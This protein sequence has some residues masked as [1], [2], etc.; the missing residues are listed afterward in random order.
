MISE[1]AQRLRESSV[2]LRCL[3]SNNMYSIGVLQIPAKL[4]VRLDCFAVA[5]LGPI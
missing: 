1:A 2:E 4:S 3:C 5:A